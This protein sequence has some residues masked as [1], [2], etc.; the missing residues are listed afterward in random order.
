MVTSGD[1]TIHTCEEHFA[2]T[3]ALFNGADV[4]SFPLRSKRDCNY[5]G[6]YDMI[7][8]PEEG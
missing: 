1:F 6:A 3:V 8:A 5:Q 2:D 7:H 4:D